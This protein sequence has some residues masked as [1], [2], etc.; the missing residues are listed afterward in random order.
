M[1]EKLFARLT[2]RGF[3][4]VR[5]MLFKI[6]NRNLKIFGQVSGRPFPFLQQP[7]NVLA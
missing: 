6:P 7:K 1:H 2:I 5:Q 4:H 3:H